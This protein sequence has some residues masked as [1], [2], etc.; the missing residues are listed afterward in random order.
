M[1]G[2]VTAEGQ[3][4][5]QELREVAEEWDLRLGDPF[6]SGQASIAAAVRL[7]DAH[8]DTVR[9]LLDARRS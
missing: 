6:A 9:W 5:A 4:S 7:R 3:R 1:L 8:I 2:A